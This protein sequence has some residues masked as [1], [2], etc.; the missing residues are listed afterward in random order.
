MSGAGFGNGWHITSCGWDG[1]RRKF[2]ITHPDKTLTFI[3]SDHTDPV[4]AW[5]EWH[6]P[7]YD[8]GIEP[9]SGPWDPQDYWPPN[10]DPALM[11]RP[12]RSPS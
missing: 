10:D 5:L 4:E 12:V 9:F 11:V 3:T 8:A 1:D 2:K 6:E 7:Y